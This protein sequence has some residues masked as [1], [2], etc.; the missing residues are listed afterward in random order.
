MTFVDVGAHIGRYTIRAGLK[1]GKQGRIIAIEPNKNNYQLLLKNIN[2]NGL[3]N[4]IPLNIAAYCI[5]SELI[6]FTGSDSAKNSIKTNS[7]R[8]SQ[9]VKAKTLDNVLIENRIQ[10]VDLIKIDVEGAEY[11]VLKGLERTLKQNNPIL[12]VE[13]LRKDENKVLR[14]MK[15]LKYKENAIDYCPAY[16]GGLTYYSFKKIND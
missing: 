10:K 13:V 11:D 3:Q 7:R 4:C 16:E 2:L 12:M 1:A 15:Q 14:Y 6:L 8:G 9:K 5:D